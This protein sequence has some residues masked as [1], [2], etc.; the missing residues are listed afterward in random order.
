MM[1][2]VE[3][4]NNQFIAQK[5]GRE[6]LGSNGMNNGSVGIEREGG[7]NQFIAQKEG[8]G[9]LSSNGMNNGNVGIKREGEIVL[10]KRPWTAA[11]DAALLDM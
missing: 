4:G 1:V 11:K 7:N 6:S 10:K 9:S 8:R 2:M 5:E 3:G